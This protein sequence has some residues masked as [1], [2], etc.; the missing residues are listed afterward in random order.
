MISFGC[1]GFAASV[2]I[3]YEY[4][5]VMNEESSVRIIVNYFCDAFTAEG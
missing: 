1:G 5:C 4:D 2:P 3:A